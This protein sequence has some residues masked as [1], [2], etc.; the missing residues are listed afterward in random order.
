MATVIVPSPYRGPTRG[1]GRVDVEGET[2]RDC[3]EAV[4]RAHPGFLAQ[5]L[6]PDGRVHRFV[7]LFRNG[8]AL[9]GEPLGVRLAA[10]DEVEIVAAIAGG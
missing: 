10:D 7:R 8:K 3:L 5:V 9:E 1:E 4:E 6:T 2:V